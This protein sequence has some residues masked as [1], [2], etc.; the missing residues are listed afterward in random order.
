MS[1]GRHRAPGPRPRLLGVTLGLMAVGAAAAVP[2][3]AVW[4]LAD[5]RAA[6]VFE[7]PAE[8]PPAPSPSAPAVPSRSEPERRPTPETSRFPEGTPV[9]LLGDS[10]A[11]G[12]AEQVAGSLPGRELTVEAEE[13]RRTATASALLADHAA[14]S[15]AIWVVSLGTNDNPDEFLASAESLMRL[16]GPD[17]CVLWYDVWRV[18]THDE[19][20]AQL[21]SLA[22]EHAN[23]HL[24]GWHAAAVAHPEWFSYDDVHPSTEGYLARA[25]LATAAIADRCTSS[26]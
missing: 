7:A 6:A 25:D 24:V 11:V 1:R 16:A 5:D 10:L 4:Q 12:I 21:G 23:L 17:R 20:N 19:V 13:G 14:A 22:D 18:G 8:P 3:V 9:L 2:A 26:G 15:A